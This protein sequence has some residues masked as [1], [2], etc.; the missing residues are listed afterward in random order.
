MGYF[1]HHSDRSPCPSRNPPF[2]YIRSAPLMQELLFIGGMC[3]SWRISIM[4]GDECGV[5][6]GDDWWSAIHT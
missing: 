6:T 1:I 4:T 5:M 2:A 3:I